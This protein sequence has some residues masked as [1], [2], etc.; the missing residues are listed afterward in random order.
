MLGFWS[1]AADPV[2]MNNRTKRA[3]N[4]GAELDLTFHT[5]RSMRSIDGLD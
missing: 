3:S 5:G 1:A 2:E 4:G